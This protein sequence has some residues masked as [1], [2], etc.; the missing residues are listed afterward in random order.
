MQQSLLLIESRLPINLF[1]YLAFATWRGIIYLS[2]I[3]LVEVVGDSVVLFALLQVSIVPVVALEIGWIKVV[4]VIGRHFSHFVWFASLC[5]TREK[6][7]RARRE[8]NRSQ[9]HKAIETAVRSD[10]ATCNYLLKVVIH[11][12]EVDLLAAYKVQNL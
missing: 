3:L 11:S 12:N 6:F 7:V 5:V 10:H 9:S 8:S 4:R 1:E 2:A